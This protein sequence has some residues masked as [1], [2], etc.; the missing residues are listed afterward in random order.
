MNVAIRQVAMHV[1]CAS[2][3][4]DPSTCTSL[5]ADL[6]RMEEHLPPTRD[7]WSPV[8]HSHSATPVVATATAAV[9]ASSHGDSSHPNQSRRGRLT[10]ARPGGAGPT[11]W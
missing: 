10:P 8:C 11:W 1:P 6:S 2:R 5:D 3:P 4:S 7:A 9:G